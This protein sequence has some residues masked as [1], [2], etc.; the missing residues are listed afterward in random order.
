[1]A[2]FLQATKDVIVAASANPLALAALLLLLATWLIVAL[3]VSRNKELL[4]SLNK[5]PSKDRLAA[6]QAEMGVVEIK[7]GLSPEQWLKNKVRT[8]YLVGFAMLCVTVIVLIAIL[9]SSHAPALKSGLDVTLNPSPES[10]DS[11]PSQPV[12]EGAA[13]PA[14]AGAS[15][16]DKPRSERKGTSTGGVKNAASIVRDVRLTAEKTGILAGEQNIP[17]ERTVTYESVLRD[18]RTEIAYR[19]P[20]Q[21]LLTRGGPVSGVNYLGVPFHWRYPELSIKVVNNTPQR[22]VLSQAV[23]TIV[24]SRVEL[25]P[26]LVFNEMSVN[27]LVIRNEGWGPVINPVVEFSVSEE[28]SSGELSVFAEQPNTLQ[29]ETFDAVKEIPLLK[30]VPTRLQHESLVSV[31]GKVTYGPA[32][33]RKSV[34]F[35][36]RVSLEVRAGA[37]MGASRC[38]D[39]HFAAG[40]AP[41]TLQVGLAQEINPGDGDD[42]LLRLATDK[43]SSNVVRIDF[44]SAG[45]E[46][47][48]GGEFQLDIFVPRSGQAEHCGR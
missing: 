34:Q 33:D 10:V 12:V 29:L 23:V 19:L 43:T 25:D 38:Y 42:F 41:V 28:Q 48:R 2:R 14:K 32:N 21:A 15:R 47:M 44:V 35:T 22:M 8:Y 5:L 7:G 13:E 36:T 37:G 17:A 3:R 9:V 27:K 46:R 16:S 11:P 1:M 24:S 18:G 39:V 40:V 31:S 6:L 20:Y 26:I 30:Y 45:G 4:K